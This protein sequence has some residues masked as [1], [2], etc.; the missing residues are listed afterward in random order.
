MVPEGSDEGGDEGGDSGD[1]EDDWYLVLIPLVRLSQ[2]HVVSLRA[3][4][5]STNS[6]KDSAFRACLYMGRPPL[7]TKQQRCI[8]SRTCSPKLSKRMATSQNKFLTWT[9]LAFSGRG[10]RP[11]HICSRKN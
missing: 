9:K 10:C 6:K 4:A 11:E 7:L 5:G 1:D 2:N 8:M 3:T